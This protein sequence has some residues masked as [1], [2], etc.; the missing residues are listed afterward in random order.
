M[1]AIEPKPIIKNKMETILNNF[2]LF[3]K[4]KR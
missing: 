1:L 4:N 2:L 3:D